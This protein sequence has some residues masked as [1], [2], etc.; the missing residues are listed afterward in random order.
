MF[1]YKTIRTLIR[2]KTMKFKLILFCILVGLLLAACSP[3]TQPVM[4]VTD[5]LGR[6]LSLPRSPLKIISLAP[7][8]TEILFAIG[9]GELVVGRDEVSDYPADV[10]A[11]PAVGGFAGYNLEQIA[12]LQPDL[13]L[14][15]EINSPE[16][17]KSIES[18]GLD[19]YYMANPTDF[20]E[21]FENINTIGRLVNREKQ[22]EELV[23]ALQVRLQ[24]V[25]KTLEGAETTP[26]VFYELD[27][28]DP[29]K[30]W[31]VGPGTYHT[32]IIEMA[33][34]ENI[35]AKAETNY[36]QISLEEII[37]Q[38]PDYILLADALWGV[39]PEQVAARPGWE[40]IKAVQQGNVLPFD[41]NLL[42]RAGPRLV[43]GLET[44][45]R[46]LHPELT[47]AE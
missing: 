12:S 18:L 1:R 20:D 34:A 33:K 42:D 22:A 5:D 36:P 24:R 31:S 46:L 43:E 35:A 39:T 19:I 2:N 44:I 7:S 32:T 30:P 28:S 38:N 6:E 27:A 13:I 26:K 40:A 10:L 16:L 15:A 37:Y 3:K 11:L 14:A 25:L 45:A 47:W 4:T 41:A 9:A 23:S 21:L 8:N 29:S 17:V